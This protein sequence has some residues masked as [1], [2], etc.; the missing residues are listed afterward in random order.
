MVASMTSLERVM[1]IF[2]MKMHQRL[3]AVTGIRRSPRV[4]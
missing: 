4:Y 1:Y 2:A 3:M